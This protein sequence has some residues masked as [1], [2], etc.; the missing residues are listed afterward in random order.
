MIENL[1]NNLQSLN[2]GIKVEDGNL[3]IN[4]P[5]GV[6]TKDIVDDIKV[7]KDQL[8]TLL[9]SSAGIPKAEKKEYYPLT[10]SQQR[11]WV[12]SQM[13]NGNTAYN[14]F[15][16]YELHGI[17]DENRLSVAFNSIVKRHES[18]RTI[19]KENEYGDLGQYIV[20]IEK[21]SEV[22]KFS[23]IKSNSDQDQ[24]IHLINKKKNYNFDLEKGP[25]FV[26][27]ILKISS[28]RHVLMFNMHHIIGDGW[29]MEVLS[30]EFM[31]IYNG[32]EDNPTFSLPE[33]SIQYKDYTE[34]LLQENQQEKVEKSEAYWLDKFNGDLPILEIPF[35][36]VRPK[37]KTFNGSG[38]EYTFSSELT[39][40]LNSYAQKNEATLF[41]V[42]MAGING[43]FS[44]YTNN[45]D[46][47]LG[48][49]VAGREH[50]DLEN[51]VGLYL[52]TLA[53]RT[54]VKESTS[55]FEL[56]E[57]QKATLLEAYSNQSYHFDSLL[58]KLNLQRD[59]SRSALFDVMVVLQNQQQLHASEDI[60]LNNI[61]LFPFR[62]IQNSHSKFDISF[63]FTERNDE[64]HLELEYNTDLY[65][66]EI[67]ERLVLHLAN[68]LG[69]CLNNPNKRI[70]TIDYLN[71]EE[72]RQL[73]HDFNA[74][75]KDYPVEKT[76]VDLF[77]DQVKTTP[78]AT[79]LIYEDNEFSYR[80]LDEL[81]NQLALYLIQKHNV[82][83]EDLIGI[84]LER[85]EWLVI[86]L[87]AV[88]KSGAAYVPIDPSYPK[89]RIEYIE[90]DSNC[91]VII[92]SDLLVSFKKEEKFFSTLPNIHISA[93]NLAYIIYTSGSTGNPKGVM[94]EHRNAVAM[95]SWSIREF[96][97]TDFD[98]LYAV[99]SHCFDLS[100]YEIFYPLSVGRKIRL[101]NNGLSIRDHL[102]KDEK[103][104]LNTVPSVAQALI[105]KKVSFKNVVGINLAGEPFPL[106]IADYFKDS[107][108]EVRNLY[109]PSEDTTYSTY[110]EVEGSYKSSVPIGKPLD[111]TQIYILS[112][113]LELQP[114]G[115]VGELCIS[116]SGLSRGYLHKKELTNEKFI[117]H[118]FKEGKRMYKTGDLARW[119]PDG[120]IEFF[121]RKDDQVKLRG[122]R[123]EL[124]EIEYVL[125]SQK[126]IVQNVVLVD[127]IEGSDVLVSY[128]VVEGQLDKQSLRAS[129]LEELPDYMIP[130]YYVELK[131]IPLTPNGKVDKKALPRVE[132]KDLIQQ[133]YV[134]AETSLE[135]DLVSIWKEVLGIDRIGVTD[136]FF[137]LGGHSLKVTLL[138]NKIKRVLGYELQVQDIF[139]NPTIQSLVSVISG[140]NRI[141]SID[142]P[143]TLE[144]ASYP[145]TS[146]Q[147]RIW[148]L[149]QFE[150]G[151]KAY[152]IP[153]AF[154]LK[155]FLDI[156][157]FRSA[158][159]YLI[160][161]H[162]SLR[163]IFKVD[164]K[165]EVGQYIVD[166]TSLDFEI[167]YYDDNNL[168]S[169]KGKLVDLV[170]SVYN[171]CFDLAVAPLVR[172]GLIKVANH[173]HLLVFNLHHIISDGWSIE[174]LI[175]ELF[176]TYNALLQ[177]KS[178]DLP[179][180]S[181][182]YKDY[183][184][185]QHKEASKEGIMISQQY[186]LDRFSSN[187]PVL[188]LPISKPR[189][190]VK[191][192]HGDSLKYTFS[193]DLSKGL[194]HFSDQYGASLF[195]VLMAGVNGLFSRYTNTGDIILGTPIA[196][197]NH[198]DLEHQVGLYLNTLAIRT[199][200]DPSASFE[201]LLELQ[202][203]TLLDGY[204]HQDYPFD[205]LIEQLDIHHE[206]SRSALFDVMVV[207]QNQQGLFTDSTTYFEGLEVT[208][209]KELSRKV[210]QFDMSFI[211]SHN[212]E[213]L[214]LTL[215]YNTDI[216]NF[217]DIER[218]VF[219]L[220]NFLERS[221]VSP[222]KRITDID[223]LD[224]Q[225]KRELLHDFNTTVEDYP[226][227]NTIIDLFRR[228]VA[229][230]PEA[231]ALVY[232]DKE[233]T[234]RELDKLSNQL[235]HYLIEE[236]SIDSED[237]VG[238]KLERNDCFV[239]S[240][241][242]ALKSGAAYVPID[243]SYPDQRIAYIEKDSNCK[244]TID[245]D[246]FVSF[247]EGQDF[248]VTLP[249]IDLS[250]ND[251][252]Y[253][254]Y[255]SG[256]TGKPKGVMIEHRSLVNLCFWHIDYYGLDATSRGTLYAGVGFDASVWEVYP[257]LLSGGSLYPISRQEVRYD[258][259][260]LVSFIRDHKIT[261]CYLPTKVCEGLYHEGY[262]LEGVKI[263][264]GGEAL[265]L[266]HTDDEGLT[267]YNNYGPSE[268]TVVTTSFDLRYRTS[269]R[270]PIGFPISNT[271][272]YIISEDALLQPVGVVGELCIS[273]AGL[274]RG[275]L[276]R[277]ALTNEKF[278]AHPFIEGE[279]MYKTGDLARWLP[280]GSI[281]FLGRKDDQVKIRGYRIEL[282]E[283]EHVL[284]SQDGIVQSVVL[285]DHIEGSDVLV[286]YLVVDGEL[287]KQSLRASLMKELPNY[288]IPSYYV[289]LES[290]PLTPNGKVDKKALPVVDSK[291][292]VHREY[293]EATTQIE[294]QL[295]EIWQE[296][297][298]VD[299]IGVTDNFF[300]LG[301]HSLKVTLLVNK[302]KRELSYEIQ[303][304]DVFNC[305]TIRGLIS[306]ISGLDQINSVDIPQ[307]LEQSSYPLTPSQRRIW[308]L[309][310]FKEGSKAY[311][312][313]GVFELQGDLNV[314][315]LSK[316][317]K[318][319]INRH[320]ILRTIFI[321]ESAEEV[322]QQI[323]PTENV[324][325]NLEVKN[326]NNNVF[327]KD[328]IDET[329][330]YS[331]DLSQAPLLRCTVIKLAPL[332]NLLLFNM[333][334][335]IGDGWSMEVLNKEVVTSYNSLISGHDIQLPELPIQYKDYVGWLF[336]SF[337]QNVFK[338]QEEYWLSKFKGDLPVLDL[339]TYK[340]RPRIK[341]Y[342]G[343][344]ISYKFSSRFNKKIRKF[345]ESS[346]ATLFMG[347]M[348]GL[349][350]LLSRYTGSNDII[351]GTPVAGRSHTDLEN[352]VGL[353]LNTLAIR[354][355]FNIEDD[356]NTLLSNQ[357]KLLLE[358]YSNQDYPLDSLIDNL[359][360]K[361]DTSRSALFDVL[362]VFQNQQEMFNSEKL[363]LDGIE[364]TRYEE[365]YRNVSQFDLSFV[366]LE[367]DECLELNLE[368]NTDI[369]DEDF[370]SSIPV[371]LE[372]F[373]SEVIEDPSK[374]ISEIQY[375]PTNEIDKL[376]NK[377]NNQEKVYSEEKTL[378]D[379]FLDRV[380]E[381]PEETAVLFKDKSLTYKELNDLSNKFAH[382]LIANYDIKNE[383][384]IGVSLERNE[385][386]IIAL[387]AVLKTGVGYVPIDPN[388]PQERIDYIEED[389][390]CKK[391]I[392]QK[393]IDLFKE[394]EY[395]A[396]LPEVEILSS[397]LAYII[398]TSGTTGKPKGVMIEHGNVT[399]LLGSCNEHYSFSEKDTW[400]LFHSYCFD[401][402]VWEIFGC[403]LSGGRL[404]I[405]T[406]YDARNPVSLS[407]LMR[408]NNVT[409]FSQTPSSFYNLIDSGL[410]IPSLKYVIFGGES[411]NPNKI[412]GWS[413]ENPNVDLINMYGITETTVHVTFKKITNNTLDKATSNIGQPLSFAKCYVLDNQQ[414]LVPYGMPGELYVSGSGLARG[415][416]NRSGL[417]NERFIENPFVENTKMYRTG[418]LV[419]Y[420]PNGEL[421][422]LGRSDNQVKIRGH[423]IELGE[424][425]NQLQTNECIK[426]AI[427]LVKDNNEIKEDK[428]LVA[429]IVFEEEQNASI[430]RKYL[431]NRLPEYMLPS[432]FVKIE[433]LPLTANGKV[434]KKVL[435]T[436]KE[437]KLSSGIEYIA[438][439][440]KIEERLT[441]IWQEVLDLEKVGVTDNFFEL[442]GH[443]LKAT[444]LLST[445]HNE[446]D[447]SIDIQQIFT[448]PT[449]EYLAMN[450]ENSQWMLESE[451][452][453]QT[454]KIII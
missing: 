15:G 80:E 223:Y 220:I 451:Y 26:G 97:N 305:P 269:E 186:W 368:Y 248:P 435:A 274:S 171:Y 154:E 326:I 143:K 219:H 32:L 255:T 184:V 169:D 37:I 320:E 339:P 398:Y 72:K 257:Y 22:L 175:R 14:I 310:Q 113:G 426:E 133:E 59:T 279:R 411:L 321:K 444:K 164:D 203:Q 237:L 207:L 454:K 27:E 106:F 449:I 238:I 98:V 131:E 127:H 165:G 163:T 142:I 370:I 423:R 316:A 445:V 335:I 301:G 415:Y 266:P 414:R 96:G 51:Q 144:K 429:Y 250:P 25:L 440:T 222:Q 116:G 340:G 167:D 231:T 204:S 386:L 290:I 198:S 221:L 114:V 437:L 363:E 29:S 347:L 419:R 325:F 20:P 43:L 417:T 258:V 46:F 102:V 361:R 197:R 262:R 396:T 389:S 298:G 265:N 86:S 55:F 323:I 404:L 123:I 92:D 289:E 214:E 130:S 64:L 95:L 76:I 241:L 239:I 110:Q 278:I 332:H 234:Y 292:L 287:D 317:I 362:V 432:Y 185:W 430:L 57:I 229:K 242:A 378:V 108:I 447:V 188:E 253:V 236:Y 306:V 82:G 350:G 397:N 50:Q 62:G 405:T 334:H 315:I 2:I 420:L 36:R 99:T 450:I 44:R 379:L 322:K 35:S 330:S 364:L 61:K 173:N 283:I 177:D 442:G 416:L 105:D 358:A 270:L 374:K 7:N 345:Q 359:N 146:S 228:Q 182:Q 331:F 202:K 357:K 337:E 366:F 295:V 318:V 183:A 21:C 377:S 45:K 4:A 158:F 75:T 380:R 179:S 84:K 208:P 141:H 16:A 73:L 125:Q 145:L 13:D 282:G 297:L 117:A 422:Y 393:T 94:I 256:S 151:S 11:L 201:K 153:G 313:P 353:Y 149:S 3:K 351:L 211:F 390:K 276:H 384:L 230:T 134:A 218:L 360:L 381:M 341:T 176:S 448:N 111:N 394:K 233:L 128:L 338:K 349:N 58:D 181:I 136:N 268:N 47:I 49:P 375:L 409:V 401:F 39:S 383:D 294:K 232:E 200:F 324:S 162:E 53:I 312:I 160:K 5:K 314:E 286:S 434:D 373:L 54:E 441:Q 91:K 227:D 68:F 30:K 191:S 103:V 225:E 28:T 138:V 194:Q 333:H 115:V 273:G 18:L 264:T 385:W 355:Q 217:S 246:L 147:R 67:I 244:V 122:Y 209:Y 376:L 402:S 215:E 121:G 300:E 120:N 319:V 71:V 8:I 66:E 438:P 34:W 452:N 285:M 19:F 156:A 193:K 77:V 387:F 90:K 410:N 453:Q 33:L 272:I 235:A 104:L 119:L 205:N 31:L 271:Q 93:S 189:P 418:D 291:D 367:V 24:L 288:M 40:K 245:S 140:V 400:S 336:N 412:K 252:A 187:V 70:T 425:E 132:S 284:Q 190:K 152:N 74:T 155:G 261:H 52:N 41:M 251:L 129:L 395:S 391:I 23:K 382:F 247:R 327:L 267:I 1:L 303:V 280:D 118:P 213:T 365:N 85:N 168:D 56:L 210:S 69:C 60:T 166:T 431:S 6:L 369:Y 388:Y 443:S 281:E 148:V 12:L 277:E 107:G 392:D 79:A 78:E 309:S 135:K 436:T 240:L 195:M 63:L 137:E 243:P 216:Y 424:I 9:S 372:L 428:E 413:D 180:L 100:V 124:G 249:I 354:T 109:G 112:E 344:K 65:D 308:V 259:S 328:V 192:Y 311:N 433:E 48:T 178:I 371:H 260:N 42:L 439:R 343:N 89:Q 427:V 263:L 342:N 224:D 307:V 126:G 157:K 174:V 399:S 199:E 83:T 296:V 38:F 348:A 299:K 88:L 81:S 408:D 356:F 226:L 10:P 150:E 446:Y 101:L 254:I 352:Q 275:Y 170:E 421:E 17:L 329:L 172:L 159:A 212:S 406:E 346:K 293:V 407:K 206:T 87:L 139:N 161:R 304:Q 196:G 403:L 302:I